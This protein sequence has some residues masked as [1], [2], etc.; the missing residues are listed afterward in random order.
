M[1]PVSVIAFELGLPGHSTTTE[2]ED[3]GTQSPRFDGKLPQFHNFRP[4][5]SQSQVS[6]YIYWE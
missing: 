5:R 1:A 4:P 3:Q 6:I 2:S